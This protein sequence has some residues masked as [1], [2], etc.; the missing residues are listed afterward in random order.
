MT[1]S[2]VFNIYN[3]I[4]WIEDVHIIIGGVKPYLLIIHN[5]SKAN[6]VTSYTSLEDCKLYQKLIISLVKL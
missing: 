1:K 3:S 2:D 4:I 5:N 6:Y